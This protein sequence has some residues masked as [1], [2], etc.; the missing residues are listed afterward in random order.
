M[1]LLLF[2]EKNVYPHFILFYFRDDITLLVSSVSIMSLCLSVIVSMI[3]KFKRMISIAITLI[4]VTTI[5]QLTISVILGN[6]LYSHGTSD[7][8]SNMSAEIE[9]QLK[10]SLSATGN[11]GNTQAWYNTRRSG[12]QHCSGVTGYWDFVDN[13]ILIPDSLLCDCVHKQVVDHVGTSPSEAARRDTIPVCTRRGSYDDCNPLYI[14]EQGIYVADDLPGCLSRVL[15]EFV[16]RYEI[17]QKIKFLV[18][19]LFSGIYLMLGTVALYMTSLINK[20]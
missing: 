2:L 12:D 3:F 18:I 4:L 16:Q 20:K 11:T 14:P 6:G 8:V 1:D 19:S 9:Y 10:D 13:S 5:A 15:E 7:N 17:I